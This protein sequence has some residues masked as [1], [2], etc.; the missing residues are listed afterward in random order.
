M[1]ETDAFFA[2]IAARL[3]AQAKAMVTARR[4]A[5]RGDERRWR[6]SELLW[7]RFGKD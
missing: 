4:L 1:S 5:H 3:S 6:R 7:P 2:N